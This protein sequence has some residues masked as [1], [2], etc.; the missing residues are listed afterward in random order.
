MGDNEKILEQVES[1]KKELLAEK[2]EKN[3]LKFQILSDNLTNL[4][5]EIGTKMDEIL[6]ILRENV[7][8]NDTNAERITKLEGHTKNCPV[9]TLKSELRR[10]ANETKAVRDISITKRLYWGTHIIVSIGVFLVMLIILAA[11]GA[12][13]IIKIL[14]FF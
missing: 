1:L 4:K 14:T 10:Y 6:T 3:E 5:I 2:E 8:K 11:F 7:S 9:L 12:E 13:G